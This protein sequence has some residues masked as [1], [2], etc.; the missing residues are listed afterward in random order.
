MS[1]N[2]SS[3]VQVYK[4]I[5]NYSFWIDYVQFYLLVMNP[6]RRWEDKIIYYYKI[7]IL[8][9]WSTVNMYWVSKKKK[10]F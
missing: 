3:L 6:K 5:K 9:I 7:I 1:H 8:L 2:S 10:N 4:F